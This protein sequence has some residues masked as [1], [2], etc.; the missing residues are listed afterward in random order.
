MYLSAMQVIDDDSERC[1]LRNR[2]HE[3]LHRAELLKHGLRPSGGASS[4]ST[5][6]VIDSVQQQWS[7]TPQVITI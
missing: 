2:V 1:K 7:D 6:S 3:Y 5:A 4:L